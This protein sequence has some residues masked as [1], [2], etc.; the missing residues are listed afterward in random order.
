MP[1]KQLAD[2]IASH[3][4]VRRRHHEAR[5]RMMPPSPVS[6]YYHHQHLS[7]YRNDSDGDGSADAHGSKQGAGPRLVREHLLKPL[8]IQSQFYPQ[9]SYHHEQYNHLH[10]QQNPADVYVDYIEM[11][12]GHLVPFEDPVVWR[13]YVLDFIHRDMSPAIS[14]AEVGSNLGYT[15]TSH[16]VQTA[17]EAVAARGAAQPVVPAAATV[18]DPCHYPDGFI[19]N[20]GPTAPSPAAPTA[21]EVA[22]NERRVVVN[23]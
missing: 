6:Q 12:G 13:N 16:R 11:G 10:Y 3:H 19:T 17:A 23:M 22:N 8:L 7:R 5:R 9:S 1:V 18:T 2:I 4:A 21:A 14:A 20:T 15:N